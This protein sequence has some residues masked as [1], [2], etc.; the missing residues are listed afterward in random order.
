MQDNQDKKKAGL[1][2]ESEF[3]ASLEGAAGSGADK[4]PHPEP[5]APPQAAAEKQPS[6][7]GK[8]LGHFKLLRLLGQGNMGIVIQALDINLER[9]VA[10]K[11]LRKRI[12]SPDDHNRVEQF[13]REARAAAK[14][15]HP[16]VV[17]I[18]EINQY[19][20][21]WY[22]AMELLEGDSL[23]RIVEAAGPLT[24][25]QACPLIA[26]AAAALDVAHR[27]GIIHRDIKPANL[28]IT[29]SGRCKLTDFGL[30]RMGDENDPFELARKTVGTPYFIAPEIV[31]GKSQTQAVDIYSLGCTLYFALTGKPPF[32][33]ETMQELFQKHINQPPPD[34]R[35][36]C[37]GCS[38]VLA[39]L[40]GR[41]LAKD[42][43]QRPTAADVAA[44]LR[45]ESISLYP[46]D[47]SVLS[48]TSTGILSQAIEKAL[49]SISEMPA[50]KSPPPSILM[51]IK[52]AG[53]KKYLALCAFI[54]F[55]ILLVLIQ[56][57]WAFPFR[58][59]K[60]ASVK[61][62]EVR[63]PG[64]RS[65]YGILPPHSVP[66]LPEQL[67]R[68]PSFSWIGKKDT[69][70]LAYVAAKDGRYFFSLSDPMAILI[71]AD[72]FVGYQTAEQARAD[73]K[74][75]A[76]QNPVWIDTPIESPVYP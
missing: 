34:V 41:M 63:F 30:V 17:K 70:G 1:E 43:A 12:T 15:E 28:M 57:F 71:P 7:T 33:A 67:N 61:Q 54:L 58:L 22:I 19:K 52:A 21:W 68:P 49:D 3:E 45:T 14:I 66:Q 39:K 16:N 9:L 4:I 2:N 56:I 55:F 73:G 11:V 59:H 44:V 29:R 50:A 8:V 27:E 35:M 60:T 40:I 10:L 37:S 18:Y 53:R 72:D 75:P 62:L 47:S 31:E 38:A 46:S 5:H 64:S 51:R 13:L 25:Q 6:W 24:A 65:S 36:Q 42:P 26:D 20:G 76:H 69:A 23:K 74:L 32:Q 48:S